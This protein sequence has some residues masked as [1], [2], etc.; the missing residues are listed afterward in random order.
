VA[1][2]AA[3]FLR[4]AWLAPCAIANQ[5]H[6]SIAEAV[7]GQVAANEEST[8]GRCTWSTHDSYDAKAR[9]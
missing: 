9:V 2:D 5:A 6:G 8:A 7:N 3:G 4:V 1:Q